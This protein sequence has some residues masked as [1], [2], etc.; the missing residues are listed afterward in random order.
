[1]LP[2]SVNDWTIS[3]VGKASPLKVALNSEIGSS[4]RS[5]AALNASLLALKML[6]SKTMALAIVILPELVS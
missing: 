6:A 2:V 1:M 3:G 4:Q 5:W